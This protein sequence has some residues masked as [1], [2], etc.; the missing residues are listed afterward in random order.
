MWPKPSPAPRRPCTWGWTVPVCR[1]A[2]PRSKAAAASS[3]TVRPRPARSSWPPCGRPKGATRRAGPCATVG[4][5]A[6]T[7]RSRARPAATPTRCRPPSPNVPIARRNGAASTPR[8]AGS[9]SATA[10]PGSGS[11]PPSS[12]PAPSKSSTSTTPSSICATWPRPSTAPERTWPT[13][14]PG[15]GVPSWT[16]AGSAPSSRRYASM[17]R[18]RPRREGA[19]TMCSG[20]DTA[21]AIRSSG[22][23]ACASL[24]ASSRPD[25]SRSARTAQVR[26]HALDRRWRQRH[27]RPALLPAQRPLRGLLGA[28]S[29]KRRLRGVSQ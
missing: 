10:P 18:P 26:R 29:R 17:S 25:A 28:S 7:L 22:P 16:P 20:T 3:P 21:C 15:T 19:F 8:P 1:C 5:S 12:F 24:R 23:R 13:S 14:G 11:W 6:T 9:S 4:R 2:P 27:H